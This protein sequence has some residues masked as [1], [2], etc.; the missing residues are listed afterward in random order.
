MR[1]TLHPSCSN[2]A[3]A[4]TLG[5]KNFRLQ[6]REVRLPSTGTGTSG[7]SQPGQ[8]GLPRP[9]GP[10]RRQ[11]STPH[12]TTFNPQPKALATFSTK[13]TPLWV[14]QRLPSS[15]RRFDERPFRRP[16]FFFFD[17]FFLSDTSKPTT[18]LAASRPDPFYLYQRRRTAPFTPRHDTTLNRPRNPSH[19]HCRRSLLWTFQHRS[20][21]VLA[22]LTTCRLA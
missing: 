19:I 12:I 15:P 22:V 7:S 1:Q 16:F 8:V 10:W 4:L 13:T 6:A 11:N 18:I 17:F 5:P 20:R 2:S 3:V 14:D 9:G 21:K